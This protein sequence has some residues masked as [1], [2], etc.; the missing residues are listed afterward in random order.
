MPW[1]ARAIWASRTESTSRGD[2]G[3]AGTSPEATALVGE[4]EEAMTGGSEGGVT[5]GWYLRAWVET[6]TRGMTGGSITGST[7]G[8]VNTGTVR[9][10]RRGS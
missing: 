3:V 5:G 9:S 10:D 1:E 6:W 8:G 7:T 2:Q 4:G